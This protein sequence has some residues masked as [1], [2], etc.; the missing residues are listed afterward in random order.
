MEVSMLTRVAVKS[1]PVQHVTQ[2]SLPQA[3][4]LSIPAAEKQ[5]SESLLHVSK[6]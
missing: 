3:M 5:R 2:P 4:S 1:K 6:R